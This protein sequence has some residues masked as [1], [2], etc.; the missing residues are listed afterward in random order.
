MQ[1]IAGTYIHKDCSFFYD[2][3]T[4]ITKNIY[5]LYFSSITGNA[6]EAEKATNSVS[7]F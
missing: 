6:S 3:E 1:K 5:F 7:K 4:D 2:R